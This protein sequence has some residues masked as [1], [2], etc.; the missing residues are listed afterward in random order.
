MEK[1]NEKIIISSK[2]KHKKEINKNIYY[3]KARFSVVQHT[4]RKDGWLANTN[5]KRNTKHTP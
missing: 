5:L 3:V 2:N 1:A 4:E